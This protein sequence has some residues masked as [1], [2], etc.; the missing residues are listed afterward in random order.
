M[1]YIDGKVKPEG[2]HNP[3]KIMSG[4]GKFEIY[5]LTLKY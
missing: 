1:G 5:S 4:W 3:N 2:E